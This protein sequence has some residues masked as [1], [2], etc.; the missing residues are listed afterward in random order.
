MV[1]SSW[2][3]FRGASDE[4]YTTFRAS[5]AVVQ[6][7]VASALMALWAVLVA[8]VTIQ[9]C[10]KKLRPAWISILLLS[11]LMLCVL[12]DSPAGYISDLVHFKVVAR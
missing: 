8:F 12:Y 4:P 2:V 1:L 9:V 6:I 11:A 7:G 10:G 5:D 3:V